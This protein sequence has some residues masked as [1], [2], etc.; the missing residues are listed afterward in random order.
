[1]R[2][3]SR[4]AFVTRRFDHRVVADPHRRFQPQHSTPPVSGAHVWIGL[5]VQVLGGGAAHTERGSNRG[6]QPARLPQSQ[7]EQQ[8]RPCRKSLPGW[9]TS[10]S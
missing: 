6:L 2:A 3:G 5:H 8:R 4:C 10:R 1:M 9:T 7:T